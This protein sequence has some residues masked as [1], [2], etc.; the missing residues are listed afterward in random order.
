VRFSKTVWVKG[1]PQLVLAT[2]QATPGTAYYSAGSGT[3]TL[4]FL[5]T[6]AFGDMISELDCWSEWALELNG[7][8]IYSNLGID[9]DLELPAP[10]EP[11]SLGYNTALSLDTVYPV[12]RFYRPDL[13]RYFFTIDENEKEH[14]IDNAADVWQYEGPAYHA[15]LPKQ[16]KAAAR[17][18]RNALIAVHRFYSQGLQTHLLTTNEN[19]KEHLIAEKADVWRY[20]GPA[21]YIP[22][23]YQ[24]GALPVYRF[25]SDDLR[26]HLFTVDENE[27]NHLI[28]T[29][30]DV[31]RYEGVAFYAYP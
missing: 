26:V 21:F 5:Y 16:Y 30:G 11:G 19:E 23:D 18:Q 8:E 4:N 29:A 2:G 27:K 14:L 3:E 17:L 13:L 24:E 31:W 28:N 25:Y 1:T 20:E 10:G 22:S 6:V 9:A 7:G 15:F 12:H